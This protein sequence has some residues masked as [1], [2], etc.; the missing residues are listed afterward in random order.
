MSQLALHRV[1][2]FASSLGKLSYLVHE[3][4]G[5]DEAPRPFVLFLHGA[6]ERGE[7]TEHVAKHGLPYEIERGKNVPFVAVSP[8]CPRDKTWDQMVPALIELIDALVPQYKLDVR[9]VYLTGLSMGGFGVWRLAA[10]IPERVAALAPVCGGANPEWATRLKDVPTWA[11]HGEA[12]EIVPVAKSRAIVASLEAL[13]A[14]VKL[15]VYPGLGHD[16]WTRTYENDELYDWM[17][18][19]RRTSATSGAEI[20]VPTP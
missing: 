17:L 7:N 16:S 9:R 15:T 2:T 3:P 19:Q 8:Q 1:H 10:E 4:P 12:D 14:P 6:G 18:G 11:F 20:N 5:W 13:G